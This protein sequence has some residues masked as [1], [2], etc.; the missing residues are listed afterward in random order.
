MLGAIA[1]DII[2]SVYEGHSPGCKEFVLFSSRATFTDDT[3]LTVAVASALLHERDY[4]TELR[5]WGR[6]Y[7]GA[8]YGHGFTQWLTDP[9]LSP[10]HSCGNGCAMR[11]SPVGWA[12]ADPDSVAAQARASALPSHGHPE[13]IQGAQAVAA[14][15]YAAR[16]GASKAQIAELIASFGF[17]CTSTMQEQRERGWVG[18]TCREAVPAAAVAFLNSTDFEDA[19]RN[20]VF[21][22][23]DTD[24]TA[25][26]AGSIAEA[27]YGGVPPEIEAVVRERLDPALLDVVDRFRARFV[28]TPSMSGRGAS[29]V[30]TARPEPPAQPD[31]SGDL[32]EV[33]RAANRRAWLAHAEWELQ[34]EVRER[35]GP[36]A[37]EWPSNDD[38]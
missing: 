19:V 11:V 8:G 15:V 22:G 4:A 34:A 36:D 16:R 18:V 2:G 20:A 7:P 35:N 25:C 38:A 12:F 1:G 28:A 31:H 9:Q 21:L 17:D 30:G 6:R 13:G 3:V 14:A 27:Y 23:G 29:A 24:T 10:G 32:A 5:A 33:V 37:V 26:I